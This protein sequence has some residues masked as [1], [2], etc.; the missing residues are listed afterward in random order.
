MR[1]NCVLLITLTIL[2]YFCKK[3]KTMKKLITLCSTGILLLAACTQPNQ[4]SE[5]TV[6][7]NL[8]YYGDTI[9]QEGA[10]A[11]QEVNKLLEGKDT[12]KTK[13]SGTIESVC[14]KKGCWMKMNIGHNQEMMVRFKD[15]GFFMPKDAAGKNIVI[16]GFAFKAT[17]SVEELKHY[18]EDAGKSK[19]EI[20]KITQAE[21][22][23]AF[24]ANG[25]IIKN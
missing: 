15:Y 2:F 1:A 9:N 5:T 4:P 24:E 22:E 16:E 3:T 6:A 17:T 18:A 19:E 8:Q 21:T 12:V 23:I 14:Q 7:E 25:V 11:V 13:L 10:V 20:E